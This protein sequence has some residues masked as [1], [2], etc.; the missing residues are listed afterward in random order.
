MGIIFQEGRKAFFKSSLVFRGIK[1]KKK[2]NGYR[3]QTIKG[4]SQK[5]QRE[6]K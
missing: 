5:M 2:G 6:R 3:S 1:E 4:K